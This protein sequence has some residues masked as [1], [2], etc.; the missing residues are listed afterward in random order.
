M[1]PTSDGSLINMG[2]QI[3]QAHR[4]IHHCTTVK[5][6]VGLLLDVL[7]TGTLQCRLTGESTHPSLTSPVCSIS[8]AQPYLSSLPLYCPLLPGHS[9]QYKMKYDS[10]SPYLIFFSNHFLNVMHCPC[11]AWISLP[12]LPPSADPLFHPT[13][14]LSTRPTCILPPP[15]FSPSLLPPASLLSLWVSH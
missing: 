10:D 4:W 5:V 2:P 12:A 8:S 14:H 13:N 9:Q 1:E 15:H 3:C 11:C 6:N 7:I